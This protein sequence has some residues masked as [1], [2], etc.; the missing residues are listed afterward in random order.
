MS[1]PSTA[2]ATRTATVVELDDLSK[3]YG[4]QVILDGIGLTIRRGDFVALLGP[5]G[6]GKTTLLRILG[7]LEDATSGRATI[8]D[9][10]SVVFQAVSYTHLTLPTIAEV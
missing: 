4:E 2:S 9:K 6:T 8:A 7:R 3:S 1:A 5:S 10:T